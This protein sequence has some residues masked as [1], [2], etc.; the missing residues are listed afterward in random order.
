MA[1]SRLFRSFL[2]AFQPHHDVVA[3]DRGAWHRTRLRDADAR[4]KLLFVLGAITLNLLSRNWRTSAVIIALVVVALAVDRG[5]DWKGFAVRFLPGIMIATPLVI[6][7]ALMGPAPY[8]A[9]LHA[10]PLAIGLSSPGLQ[11][12]VLLAW[13]VIAGLAVAILLM[14]TT[15][16]PPLLDAFHWLRVPAIMVEVASL[17]YRYLFLLAEEGGRMREAQRLRSFKRRMGL[18]VADGSAL[19]GSMFIRSYDRAE[20]VA[21]AQR[22]RGGGGD[23]RRRPL[24][25]RP[26]WAE[27]GVAAC[28]L[29]VIGVTLL[30]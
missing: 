17:I 10:G 21:D 18:S 6:L 22:V 2:H 4:V 13:K 11:A 24:L 30:L 9:T 1:D 3:V 26:P 16:L 27:T 15:P 7:R 29:V 20:R 25:P 8:L 12:G 23:T 5:R 28:C 14:T 19:V